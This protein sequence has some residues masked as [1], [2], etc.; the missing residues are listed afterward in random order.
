[1]MFTGGWKISSLFKCYFKP[2]RFAVFQGNYFIR[3]FAFYMISQNFYWLKSECL[4]HSVLPF[5]HSTS[6]QCSQEHLGYFGFVVFFFLSCIN[7]LLQWAL[8]FL[9]ISAKDDKISIYKKNAKRDI[10][11]KGTLR[12]MEG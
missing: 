9:S 6:S 3:Y 11:L 2:S 4:S 5:W 10:L 12:H 1:M 7:L 8:F